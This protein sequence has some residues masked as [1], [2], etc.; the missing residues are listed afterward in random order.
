MGKETSVRE[1]KE[2]QL[3]HESDRIV[4]MQREIDSYKEMIEDGKRT[5]EE[6]DQ[7]RRNEIGA[8]EKKAHQNWVSIA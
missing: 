5:Y 7:Q 6:S 8:L 4:R 3:A 1:S 2:S